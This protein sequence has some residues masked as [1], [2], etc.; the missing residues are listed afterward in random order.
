MQPRSRGEH[1][2]D[3]RSRGDERDGG[4]LALNPIAEL[5][6]KSRFSFDPIGVGLAKANGEAASGRDARCGDCRKP[7]GEIVEGRATSLGARADEGH[8]V[9]LAVREDV[10]AEHLRGTPLVRGGSERP[11]E[12]G[13]DSCGG[14][15]RSSRPN[16]FHTA[17]SPW[18]V[19]SLPRSRV[20]GALRPN[21]GSTIS[22][23]WRRGRSPGPARD[24]P[25][26]PRGRGRRGGT[27]GSGRPS[28]PSRRS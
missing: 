2:A 13:H 12:L 10:A 7:A 9:G 14:D 15:R 20:T 1:R 18:R 27:T 21:H 26:R 17:S 24:T 3:D 11:R 22:S 19:M 4:A 25:R 6:P 5:A 28:R 8:V 23:A 16:A